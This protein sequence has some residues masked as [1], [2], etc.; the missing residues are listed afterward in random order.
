M[1]GVRAEF[2]FQQP[3]ECTVATAS[4]ETSDSLTD[5]SWASENGG[6]VAEQFTAS[7]DLNGVAADEVFDYGSQRVYEFDRDHESPCICEFI[8]ESL[9]PVTDVYANSGNLHVTLH[10]GD[11]ERLRALLKN[12]NEKFGNV[13]IEYLVQGREDAGEA[14]LVPV[15]LRRLTDRQHEVIQ[16]AH[17]MG[18]F[19]YPRDSNASEVAEALGIQP[20]TFTEHLN[21]AQSKLLEELLIRD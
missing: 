19:E 10:A 2:V 15:D 7:S 17:E 11:M 1:T 4:A 20:S 9:G 3:E 13:R 16:T 21:A 5:I 14:E 6:S 18:Y 12:L 8:E